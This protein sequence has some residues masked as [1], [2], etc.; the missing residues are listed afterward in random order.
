MTYNYYLACIQLNILFVNQN[1][2][3]LHPLHN[4]SRYNSKE[5]YEV[6]LKG[7]VK[8]KKDFGKEFYTEK[9]CSSCEEYEHSVLDFS[10][11]YFSGID[12]QEEKSQLT[13]DINIIDS[14]YGQL[15]F[16]SATSDILNPK[17]IDQFFDNL[18][19]RANDITDMIQSYEKD[20]FKEEEENEIIIKYTKMNR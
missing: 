13:Q 2:D 10:F 15:L 7:N 16:F 6:L 12:I 8:K 20:H 4:A 17:K 5:T 9:N 1:L 3:I 18:T 11:W 14:S 19:K